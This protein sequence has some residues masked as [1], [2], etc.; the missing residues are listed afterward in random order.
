MKYITFRMFHK[1]AL[2][3][4]K[5]IKLPPWIIWKWS[6]SRESYLMLIKKKKKAKPK[7]SC[8]H[9]YIHKFYISVADVKLLFLLILAHLQYYST[10]R[11]YAS[12]PD[13]TQRIGQRLGPSVS[14][15]SAFPFAFA[16]C[17]LVSRR[18]EGNKIFTSHETFI[19]GCV[20]CR[21]VL[22]SR[23]FLNTCCLRM[24]ECPARVH[25][26]IF[27]CGCMSLD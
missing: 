25:V 5:P 16:H 26:Y 3:L 2:T 18:T 20:G 4:H 23:F 14:I 11:I 1:A 17:L 13:F 15:T 24:H 21:G 19:A 12:L 27:L 7:I 6:Q 9:N 8:Q 10:T 22:S